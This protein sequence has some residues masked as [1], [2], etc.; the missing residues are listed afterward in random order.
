[1]LTK[2]KE[3]DYEVYFNGDTI[4]VKGVSLIKE[5]EHHLVFMDSEHDAIC[6]YNICN[7]A[8][9]KRKNKGE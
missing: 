6:M 5:G 9:V 2:N 8:W 7:V 1:V 3:Y 4:T